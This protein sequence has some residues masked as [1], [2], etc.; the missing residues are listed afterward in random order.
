MIDIGHRT[1]HGTSRRSP[2][3]Q[4]VRGG[5]LDASEGAAFGAAYDLITRVAGIEVPVLLRGERGTGKELAARSIHAG[6]P[7]RDRIFLKAQCAAA[8]HVLEPLLFGC[9]GGAVAGTPHHRP[10]QLEFANHG[11]L[12]LERINELPMALQLRLAPVLQEGGFTRVGSSDLRHVDVRIV[13]STEED[14]ERQTA[15]GRFRE[16]LHCRLN[17]VCITLPPLRQRRREL[18]ELAAFFVRQYAAHYNRSPVPLS[19]ATLRLFSDYHWP[20]N[21]H[22]LQSVIRKIVTLGTEEIVRKEL[23]GGSPAD[24]AA[25]AESPSPGE[26][27][28]A[29]VSLKDLGRRAAE[30]AERELI[31]KTLQQTRW[32]RREAADVLGV[33][34]KALLYKIKKAELGGTS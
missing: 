18:P 14:L 15:E 13:A 11:T 21:I 27:D 8:P 2:R 26:T 5:R 33:S 19:A 6:S 12:F 24:S 32:N 23:A 25:V 22:Q 16:E 1:R 10:G 34:Y 7:R 29:A 20:G 9:E 31:F 30:S 28:D 17:V 3:L 4:L